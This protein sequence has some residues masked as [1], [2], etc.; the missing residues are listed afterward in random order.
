M[1]ILIAEDEYYARKALAQRVHSLAPE[2]E[3][4]ECENG[5]VAMEE[6]QAK[7]CDILFLDVA[8]PEMSGLEVAGQVAV[9][10]P[11]AWM[12][13]LTGFSDFE[14]ARTAI[15]AGVKEYLLKPVSGRDLEHALRQGMRAVEERQEQM[16]GLAGR[17]GMSRAVADY[18]H[19]NREDL[20]EGVEAGESVQVFML[21]PPPRPMPVTPDD[22]IVL[23]EQGYV[24]VLVRQTA[25]AEHEMLAW[26]QPVKGRLLLSCSLVLTM[27]ELPEAFRQADE[28]MG[29]RFW[30]NSLHRYETVR[31]LPNTVLLPAGAEERFAQALGSREVEAEAFVHQLI[32]DCRGQAVPPMTLK[33][34]VD[35]LCGRMNQVL[36]ED[37]AGLGEDRLPLVEMDLRRVLDLEEIRVRLLEGV[38]RVMARKSRAPE[39]VEESVQFL[40]RY[41]EMHYDENISFHEL[42][43]NR[44]FMNASYLSRQFHLRMGMSFRDYLV[45][46][47]MERAR[48]MLVR[49]PQESIVSIARACGYADASQFI[50][51]FRRTW[52]MTPSVYRKETGNAPEA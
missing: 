10:W 13:F 33:N 23:E 41:V 18:V 37:S 3:I 16:A 5:L 11:E 27:A 32:D 40:C 46:C 43:E 48:E 22:W 44:L 4:V 30:E 31:K 35:R 52:G 15:R 20:P 8:M 2:C 1:R 42:A 14:Y 28:A 45:R 36:L 38:H 21:V 24:L 17:Y 12:I 50:A 9:H 29:L 7:P 19:G 47:R 51:L 39:S 25:G 34:A 49:H 26:A 6:M